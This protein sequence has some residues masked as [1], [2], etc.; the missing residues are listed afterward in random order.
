MKIKTLVNLG[1][2]TMA[3]SLWAAASTVTVTFT[4][5]GGQSANPTYYPYTINVNNGVT[6]KSLT[7][8]CD[9]FRDAVFVGES[10]QA[11]VSD[12]SNPPASLANTLYINNPAAG[13]SNYGGGV[14]T[15]LQAY[16]ELAFLYTQL[17]PV[18]PNTNTQNQ[19]INYAMW[20]LFNPGLHEANGATG[21]D[22]T[23]G[24]SGVDQSTFWLTQALNAFN[25][26]LK[27][28]NLANFVIY[29]P[30]PT[31]TT[32]WTLDA[33]GKPIQPQEFIG[34]VPEPASLALLG[35]G[36]LILGLAFRRR[37]SADGHNLQA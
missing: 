5:N 21:T 6:T 16:E 15:G 12:F 29:S 30:D 35:T 23:L 3:L 9:D 19:A 22:P 26:G 18:P 2:A 14:T 17:L 37:L 27:G 33:A 4:S 25:G 36:L 8:A 7:V 20:E 10:F 31:N 32:G 34:E 11:N 1:L 13:N 28:V 24:N